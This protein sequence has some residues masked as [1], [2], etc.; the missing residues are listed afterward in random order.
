MKPKDHPLGTTFEYEGTTLIVVGN[1]DGKGCGACYFFDRE[2]GPMHCTS[3]FRREK[4]E[5]RFEEFFDRD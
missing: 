5:V 1:D 2:C 4:N 3:G